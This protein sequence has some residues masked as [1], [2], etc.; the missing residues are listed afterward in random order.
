MIRKLSLGVVVAAVV[1]TGSL[2]QAGAYLM[3]FTV[4]EGDPTAAL[5]SE[6][7]PFTDVVCRVEGL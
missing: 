4:G 1:L 5:R 6:V 3:A 2:G 7:L